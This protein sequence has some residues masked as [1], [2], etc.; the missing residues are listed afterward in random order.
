MFK[1]IIALL[2][3]TSIIAC[4]YQFESQNLCVDME[5]TNGPFDG[6]PSNFEAVVYD[7]DSGEK[8]APENLKVY[9]WMMMANGHQHGGPAIDWAYGEDQVIDGTAKFFMG[10][11]KGYWQV[12]FELNEEI[13]AVDVELKK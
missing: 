5:W 10:R 13:V 9:V 2:L 4:P 1:T 6:A 8:I 7:K 3:T 12:R 11:M